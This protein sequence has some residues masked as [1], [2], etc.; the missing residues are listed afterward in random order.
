MRTLVQPRL[1][2]AREVPRTTAPRTLALRR[3]ELLHVDTPP[4]HAPLVRRPTPQLPRF[5]RRPSVAPAILQQ[6]SDP[7]K[8]TIRGVDLRDKAITLPF[9][10]DVKT[11]RITAKTLMK[12]AGGT[13]RRHQLLKLVGDGWIFVG[14]TEVVDLSDESVR[15]RLGVV[16]ILS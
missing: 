1:P 15:Y 11:R 4:V 12:L 8:F 2:S 13:T 5:T 14:P 10:V 16:E 9:G 6:L 3:L 7:P